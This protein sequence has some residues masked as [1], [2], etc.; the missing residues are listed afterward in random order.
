MNFSRLHFPWLYRSLHIDNVPERHR[1]TLKKEHFSNLDN[2]KIECDKPPQL[3]RCQLKA[4]QGEKKNYSHPSQS[5][6][7]QQQHHVHY[8]S[9]SRSQSYLDFSLECVSF[10]DIIFR[11]SRARLLSLTRSTRREKKTLCGWAFF[12]VFMKFEPSRRHVTAFL[13]LSLCTREQWFSLCDETVS[14]TTQKIS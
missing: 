9:S 11:H 12:C 6:R 5:R 7:H 2:Y 10:I 3:I 1:R 14:T 4:R 8:T 13:A